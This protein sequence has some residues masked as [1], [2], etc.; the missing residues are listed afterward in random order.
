MATLFDTVQEFFDDE[1][2]TTER[3]DGV[4]ALRMQFRGKHG[5]WTCYARVREPQGQLTFYSQAPLTVPEE[6]RDEM[7]AFI[8]RANYGMVNG[9]FELDL[10]DGDLRFK[11]SLDL[12]PEPDLTD[13]G[14]FAAMYGRVIGANVSMMDRYLAGIT[15][16]IGGRAAA[17]A[18]A[19]IEEP[20]LGP[21]GG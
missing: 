14:W 3:M 2:W 5:E 12:G 16:V 9:N 15:A 4:T 1:D 8:T 20:E 17:E 21:R 13:L 19:A 7:A 10:D 18:V 11:T 6:R